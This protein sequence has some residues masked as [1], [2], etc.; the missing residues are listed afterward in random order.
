MTKFREF[1]EAIRLWGYKHF[2]FVVGT[3]LTIGALQWIFGEQ[4]LYAIIGLVALGLLVQMKDFWT[5]A[6]E[7]GS[8]SFKRVWMW[9]VAVTAYILLSWSIAKIFGSSTVDS[10]T[11][12]VAI[13]L[14]S[15]VLALNYAT[16][17]NKGKYNSLAIFLCVT[18]L[19]GNLVWK[20]FFTEEFKT[21]IENWKNS[22]Q[23]GFASDAEK[24]AKIRK[25]RKELPIEL[26]VNYAGSP[27]DLRDNEDTLGYPQSDWE[28][29]VG[30]T[31]LYY[32]VLISGDD[33]YAERLKMKFGEP[34]GKVRI[35]DKESGTFLNKWWSFRIIDKNL[36]S[37]EEKKEE[38]AGDKV[39]VAMPPA[40]V[41]SAIPHD[42]WIKLADG[43]LT[44]DLVSGQTV[45][46]DY[47]LS[48]NDVTPWFLIP[49]NYYVIRFDDDENP[50][51]WYYYQKGDVKYKIV[52]MQIVHFPETTG[53]IKGRFIAGS[54]GAKIVVSIFK[55]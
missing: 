52:P 38:K 48:P 36:L 16:L 44:V 22:A 53:D 32:P 18:F 54:N 2:L 8:K 37:L 55:K 20:D 43:T 15:I 10:P 49:S 34:F 50:D 9:I 17:E 21:S 11:G 47:D 46:K 13:T 27:E 4:A 25:N 23:E 14:L 30:D 26:V 31:V 12:L 7:V 6:L 24:N 41:A 5:K 29:S 35:F 33:V 1:S 42:P 40:P 28:I 19:V 3:L 51:H 39:P 45:K